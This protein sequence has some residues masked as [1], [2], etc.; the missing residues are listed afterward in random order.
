MHIHK[1]QVLF[2]DAYDSFSNNIISLLETDLNA[3]V[4]IVKIDHPLLTADDNAALHEELTH[5]SAVVCGPGPGNPGNAKD[6]GIM[7]KIWRLGEEQLLPVLGICLGF[8][9]LCLEF[10]G[11]IRR[12]KGPQHGMIRRAT[13]IGESAANGNETI[14]GGV[15]E[16]QAVLYQSLCVDIGQD[17]ILDTDWETSKWR[18][19]PKCK[20]LLPLAWVECNDFEADYERSCGVKDKR[21]LVAVQHQ[22][23]PFWA[24]Q[25]HPE[26]ICTNEESK[27]V[28]VN[29]FKE[30]QRWN[31][32]S[33]RSEI[34]YDGLV[35]G[36][37]PVH[38]SLLDQYE[39]LHPQEESFPSSPAEYATSSPE[40]SAPS[41]PESSASSFPSSSQKSRL[42]QILLSRTIPLPD[43]LSVPDIVECIQDMNRNHIILE[44]SNSHE[45]DNKSEAVTGRYSII[46]LDVDDCLRFEYRAGS[47]YATKFPARISPYSGTSEDINLKEFGG[48]WPLLAHHLDERQVVN[49]N[50]DSPFW[51]GF[52][53]YTTY[54]L[55][56]EGINVKAEHREPPKNRPDLCFAW[57]TRSLVVD[58]LK[59]LIYLQQL[60]SPGDQASETAWMNAVVPQ[61]ERLTQPK[62]TLKPAFKN[63]LPSGEIIMTCER[64]KFTRSQK[65]AWSPIRRPASNFIQTI[66][67]PKPETYE[68][69]VRRCQDRIRAG[70]SYELCLTD[71]TTITRLRS[72]VESTIRISLDDI[73]LHKKAPKPH[74]PKGSW[75]LYKNLR[76]RSPAPFASYLRLGSATLISSSPERFLTW[77]RNGIC[78]LRPMKGTVRKTPL[79]SP[80]SSSSSLEP[81]TLSQATTLLSVPKEKAENLMIV[82]LVRHD[83]HSVCGSGAVTVPNLMTIEEYSSVFT[84]TSTVT[85]SVPSPLTSS[86][87]STKHTG[88]DVLCSSLPPGSMTGAPKIRSCEILQELESDTGPRSI[89]SGV[90]GYID[91]GGRGDWSVTIRSAYRWDDENET[92]DCEG[93]AREVEKWHV[94]AGGAVTVLST[95]VGEREEMV[96][97]A[98]GVLGVFK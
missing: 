45:T 48:I 91:V 75:T 30:A 47:D 4:R 29:W 52:M 61:L 49:G 63:S 83:L 95:A 6:A 84:M 19:S 55:G 51:G 3:E 80:S 44:S 20:D 42:E 35:L 1:P 36:D 7:K 73:L 26:S 90:V 40:N 16:I 69:K 87:T 38:E 46:G 57:I 85:S 13:H 88:L 82:D 22:T 18:A 89:Y 81:V 70:D 8:Q 59:N 74:P 24:L 93:E 25:Y 77:S 67:Q 54:E 60:T 86:S 58:H 92:R 33:R 9:S 27:Q 17:D 53:G 78:S 64:I 39:Q 14:F 10:G 31:R 23:K 72:D 12:L 71:Q 68:S 94:G 41:S 97:K 37:S 43:Q 32:T 56:L 65:R 76:K 21:V 50:E 5:Y 66:V 96:T 62:G 15:G 11:K 79:A 34:I 28:I 2:I 98:A